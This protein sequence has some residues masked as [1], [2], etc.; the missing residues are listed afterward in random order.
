MLENAACKGEGCFN[1]DVLSI[2]NFL[3]MRAHGVLHVK[4]KGL[5][6]CLHSSGIFLSSKREGFLILVF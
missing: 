6:I 3:H 1:S 2:R 4:K 5:S